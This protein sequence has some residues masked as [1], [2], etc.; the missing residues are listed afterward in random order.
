MNSILEPIGGIIFMN[1]L[2]LSQQA[3]V[4]YC[5][6]PQLVIAGAGS[7]KTRVLTHKIA[8]LLREGMPSFNILA[9][10]FTNKAAREMK[11]RVVSLV[12][13]DEARYLN[14]GTFHS[15]F[16]R[17]LRAESQL[18]GYT[19]QFTIY[20]QNDS[21]S[22]VKAI[23]KE[24]GLDKDKAY[25]PASVADRISMA[26]N[27]LL[28]PQAYAASL[29][30][31]QADAERKQPA[32]KDIY[33][34]YVERCRKAN[35]MDFDDLLVN[36]YLLFDT[37]EDV[38]KRY[39]ERFHYVLV[40]EYQ[41]T[42]GVQQA[43]LWQL[44]RERQRLC[45]VGDDAQSIYS[46]RGANIDNILEFTRKYD[47]AKLFKLEQNYRSTRAIVNA[48][49]GLISHNVRQIPKQ[50]FSDNEDG[51][52]LR[53][54]VT[55]SD[56]EE[57]ILVSRRIRQL[58]EREYKFDDIAILY[59]TNSQSRSFEECF[60]KESIPYHIVGG[61][62]F[63]QR[64]EIKDIIAYF[65]LV[66]NPDDEE[67]FKRVVN[68]PTRGIGPTTVSRL[69]EAVSNSGVGLWTVMSNP[70]AYAVQVGTAALKK[71][72]PFRQM[73]DGWRARIDEDD[74]YTLGRDIVKQSMVSRD[75]YSGSDPDDLSRQSNLEEFMA[76]LQDFVKTHREAGDDE[77]VALPSFLQEVSLLTDQDTTDSDDDS[78][79][80]TM[81]T[82][83][84]AK[85]LEFPVVF[86]V[87][88]EENIFP[89]PRSCDSVRALEEERRLLYVAITRAER[90]CVLTCAQNRF[91]FGRM[92]YDT[93]SRF[94]SDF[95]P[96]TL[97]GFDRSSVQPN[98][99]SPQKAMSDTLQNGP[100]SNFH[101]PEAPVQQR[102]S[103][104]HSWRRVQQEL[105]PKD[106]AR[107]AGQKRSELEGAVI[108]HER[109]GRGRV[110]K[111]D[112]EGENTKAKVEF[113]QAGTKQLLLK[114]ARFT[115]VKA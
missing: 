21:R 41:D 93:P 66:V 59:R 49:N 74:A 109:F 23:I 62:S 43:I 17:I 20:D 29:R 84:S 53:L 108:E 103:A 3:A 69:M 47:Y 106:G 7:G 42:N 72:E 39:V 87:G 112:G 18:L 48:A 60:R 83:H 81:M 35:A 98:A 86:I 115:V 68:Y 100:L 75:I 15:V 5:D 28:L 31:V 101:Q 105:R 58:C 32:V 36:T 63:Y 14:M 70:Q 79:K 1:E 6:G 30:T 37:H 40:D 57:A 16:S 55:Y 8:F 61:L 50:S 78:P 56:K 89:S 22:L 67:A 96:G 44:T 102:I 4:T 92:E 107:P 91:R 85:G 71:L 65:R 90:L 34:R 52:P 19:R 2:S 111:V 94:L 82:I 24:M 73:V 54:H 12:G 64:K 26:K 46:F 113:E 88:V 77:R 33:F 38:R 51:E 11:E 95:A 80:V 99:F 10:T 27:R 76:A 104:P 114:F 110:V 13:N 45:V 25:T 9:L 97:K